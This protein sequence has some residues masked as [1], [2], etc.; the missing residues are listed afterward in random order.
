MFLKKKLSNDDFLS[1]APAEIVRKEKEKH[2]ELLGR[3]EKI[4][5]SIE[6][7]RALKD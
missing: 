2:T 3:Q 5:D 7:I 4:V 6:K 1:R